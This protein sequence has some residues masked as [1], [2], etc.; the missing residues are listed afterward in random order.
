MYRYTGGKFK[1]QKQLGQ[2]LEPAKTFVDVFGGAGWVATHYQ[3]AQQ[4]K[5]RVY[6]DA[7]P[8]NANIMD[9]MVNKRKALLKTLK[10]VEACDAK[11][12]AQAAKLIHDGKKPRNCDDI[13]EAMLALY[14]RQHCFVGRDKQR[15]LAK[16][17]PRAGKELDSIINRLSSDKA[18]KLLDGLIVENLD[19]REVIKKYDSPDT[20]FY[21]DPPYWDM[22]FYYDH[23]FTKQDHKDLADQLANIQGKFVLSYYSYRQL[24]K[25]YPTTDFNHYSYR[26]NSSMKNAA[27]TKKARKSTEIVIT[28]F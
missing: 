8:I 14:Y 18:P 26:I 3:A 5:K 28:N 4:S 13:Q 12:F 27:K 20:M 9:V 22:E 15:E 19:F 23:G 11:I 1:H 24:K 25:L 6:N 21:V 16:N 7:N 2:Y 17:T 10:E